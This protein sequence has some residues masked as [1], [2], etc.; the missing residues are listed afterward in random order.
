VARQ[1]GREHLVDLDSGDAVPGLEQT[2]GERTEPGTDLDDVR[3]LLEAGSSDDRPHRI[4]V[5]D[6]VLPLL[7]RRAQTDVSG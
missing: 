4:G 7:L 3:G 5:D 2:E 1:P 6:E